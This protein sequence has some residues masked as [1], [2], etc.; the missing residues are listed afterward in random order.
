MEITVFFGNY[1]IHQKTHGCHL[2]RKIYHIGFNNPHGN[3]NVNKIQTL[4]IKKQNY[5]LNQ[6]HII[7]TVKLINNKTKNYISIEVNIRKNKVTKMK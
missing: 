3:W 2:E 4:L 6:N 1:T 7:H 5:N